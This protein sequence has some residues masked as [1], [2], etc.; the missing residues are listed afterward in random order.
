MEVSVFMVFKHWRVDQNLSKFTYVPSWVCF[1]CQIHVHCYSTTN[2]QMTIN[3]Y[4]INFMYFIYFM[5]FLI[6]LP[7]QNKVSKK[8][9]FVVDN[10]YFNSLGN[11]VWIVA[12]QFLGWSIMLIRSELLVL[13][14]PCVMG[15]PLPQP[16][17]HYIHVIYVFTKFFV[18]CWFIWK[19]WDESLNLVLP[20]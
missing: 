12:K 14:S 8:V 20:S 1:V 7:L 15:N 13:T 2:L 9:R 18:W 6:I 19:P 3:R 17:K 11:Q 4:D 5:Y 10:C 16:A